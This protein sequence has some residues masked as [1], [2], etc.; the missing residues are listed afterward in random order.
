MAT[1]LDRA[2]PEGMPAAILHPDDELPKCWDVF[3]AWEHDGERGAW[4]I[5][6]TDM[7]RLTGWRQIQ[8]PVVQVVYRDDAP[9]HTRV[10]LSHLLLAARRALT[11]PVINAYA[12]SRK[13]GAA[14]AHAATRRAYYTE[15]GID[16]ERIDYLAYHLYL[17]DDKPGPDDPFTDTRT[18]PLDNPPLPSL[19][20]DPVLAW[21]V[22]FPP[23]ELD[24]SSEWPSYWEPIKAQWPAHW[25]INNEYDGD[26]WAFNASDGRFMPIRFV[27]RG[28]VYEPTRL[29]QALATRHSRFSNRA[30][31]RGWDH[32]GPP[33]PGVQPATLSR[34]SSP[35][36]A[37]PMP[38]QAAEA[39]PVL[40]SAPPEPG[41]A[42]IKWLAER[43]TALTG[44]TSGQYTPLT[45]RR[46]AAR[47]ALSMVAGYHPQRATE[48][49]PPLYGPASLYLAQLNEYAGRVFRGEE[50]PDAVL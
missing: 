1:L 11:C 42:R 5:R 28:K 8:E 41:E 21:A 22:P 49:A 32:S 47:F 4:L 46:M 26:D 31:E 18:P 30:W 29:A 35:A 40:L 19:E 10:S 7:S 45:R 48:D 33:P 3:T 6:P 2:G 12:D 27:A 14:G 15:R 20:D 37:T 50:D 44:R 23:V 24:P 43:I 17:N 39:P 38:Q 16:I 25:P 36:P 9:V 34:D 13:Y